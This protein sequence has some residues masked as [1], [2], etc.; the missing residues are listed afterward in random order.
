[1]NASSLAKGL[2]AVI[3]GGGLLVAIGA[4]ALIRQSSDRDLLMV[5][6]ID[7]FVIGAAAFIL[8]LIFAKG[9]AEDPTPVQVQPRTRSLDSPDGH[10]LKRM[11]VRHVLRDKPVTIGF[12]ADDQEAERFAAQI[13]QF[14]HEHDFQVVGF[15][16][17]APDAGLDPGIGIDESNHILVGPILSRSS[18]GYQNVAPSQGDYWPESPLRPEA[19]QATGM[20]SP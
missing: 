5:A 6:G 15:A 17:E 8:V 13:G 12:T 9:K 20:R 14:L 11:L 16:A 2:S 18:S 3:A 1:M 4:A 19:V 10:E 7:G